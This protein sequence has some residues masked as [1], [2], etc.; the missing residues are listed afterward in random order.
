MA[1]ENKEL[2]KTVR[3]LG[4]G[5]LTEPLAHGWAHGCRDVKDLEMQPIAREEKKAV[6]WPYPK[7]SF[8]IAAARFQQRRRNRE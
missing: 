1:E 8:G 6:N 4:H 7:L 2:F 3:H 5:E